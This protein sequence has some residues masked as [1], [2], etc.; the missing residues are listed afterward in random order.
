MARPITYDKSKFLMRATELFI[1]RGFAG[2]AMRD[3]LRTTGMN[4]HSLYKVFGNKEGLYREALAYYQCELFTGIYDLLDEREGAKTLSRC[5]E[6]ILGADAP[7]RCLMIKTVVD[8]GDLEDEFFETAQKHFQRIE[9]GFYENIQLASPN[10]ENSVVRVRTD[11]LMS[12]FHGLPISTGLYGNRRLLE[13]ANA[14][15]S[16]IAS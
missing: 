3:I 15:I 16:F 12:F 5:F 8:R 2:A 11:L 13:S 6:M 9:V 7:V 14:L 10:V 4:R 1:E